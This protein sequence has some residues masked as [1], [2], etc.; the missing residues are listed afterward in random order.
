MRNK[1][2]EQ[3]IHLSL[4]YKEN[5]TLPSPVFR[6]GAGGEVFDEKITSMVF[7]GNGEKSFEHPY[8]RIFFRL[9]L[10]VFLKKHFVAGENND[11]SENESYPVKFLYQG[12]TGKY[13]YRSQ[14][15]R[16]DDTPEK[17]P[18]LIL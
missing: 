10:F 6:R 8:N 12:D 1:K 17:N 13:E 9:Y 7:A 14:N 16:P 3:E 5:T 15:Q 2:Y 18:V 11:C 4:H